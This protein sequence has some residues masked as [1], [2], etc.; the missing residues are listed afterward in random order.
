MDKVQEGI[1][2]LRAAMFG[3]IDQRTIGVF[4]PYSV[5]LP[6]DLAAKVD[7]IA[8]VSKLSK[9]QV[10]V[11]V[12]RLGFD[13]FARD[14]DP[15][16]ER[17]FMEAVKRF[18]LNLILLI[19]GILMLQ[20]TGQVVNVFTLDAGK[21]KEGKE[22]A[23]RYKVQ[24]MGNVALP[25]GGAKFDLM[26]LTVESLSDWEGL[27]DKTVSIDVGAFAPEKGSIVYFVRRGA[28]PRQVNQVIA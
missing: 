16:E 23:E 20:I 4:H 3:E 9:N 18:I 26:D 14:L 1:M 13:V 2:G 22:F 6:S 24:L 8:N 7:A 28:K 5:R 11:N 15:N 17:E 19:R 10:I 21:D 12:L 27:A 25:N